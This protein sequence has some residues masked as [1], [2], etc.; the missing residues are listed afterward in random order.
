VE[1]NV[2]QVIH[3]AP[4]D[5]ARV[6]FDPELEDRW[7]ETATKAEKLTPGP[8]GVGSRVRHESGVLGLKGPFV[9]EVTD[10]DPNGRLA[11]EIVDGPMRG[12]IIYQVAATSGG[13]IA[14]IHVKNNPKLPIPSLPWAHKHHVQED[15]H[16][17]A[18]L[19]THP[20]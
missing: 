14:T 1:F 10:F 6:M 18:T 17:L 16:R 4:A 12:L 3:R 5:V 11:M 19:L 2:E 15:L 7:T 8:I 9:T 20:K 13:S